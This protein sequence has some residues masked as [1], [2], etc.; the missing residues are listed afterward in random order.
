MKELSVI[1][2]QEVSGA[3]K[4]QDAYSNAFSNYFGEMTAALNKVFNTGYDVEAAK[5]VGKDFGSR[6][7]KAYEDFFSKVLGDLQSRL[8]N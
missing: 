1:E 2:V 8:V 6:I 5:E 3:G 7:G 4:I